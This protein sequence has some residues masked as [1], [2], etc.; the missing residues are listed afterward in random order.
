M[1][2]VYKRLLKV[3]GALLIGSDQKIVLEEFVKLVRR[4]IETESKNGS[5]MFLVDFSQT[6]RYEGDSIGNLIHLLKSFKQPL[7]VMVCCLPRRIS[8]IFIISYGDLGP[9]FNSQEEALESFQK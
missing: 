2:Q 4:A 9:F 1:M 5:I 7:S 6:V 8:E 3:R